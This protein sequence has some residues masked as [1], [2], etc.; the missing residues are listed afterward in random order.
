M[1]KQ[2][3][4]L[5]NLLTKNNYKE[6]VNFIK[7]NSLYCNLAITNDEYAKIV[8]LLQSVRSLNQYKIQ[9]EI[10]SDFILLD[11]RNLEKYGINYIPISERDR[12]YKP[13]PKENISEEEKTYIDKQI[14]VCKSVREKTKKQLAVI[15]FYEHKKR[16]KRKTDDL[17]L[18]YV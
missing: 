3:F 12:N 13:K 5:N 4:Y 16:T 9:T 15:D 6:F 8:K 17:T 7:K 1:R 10:R 11:I 18:E 14:N 2:K